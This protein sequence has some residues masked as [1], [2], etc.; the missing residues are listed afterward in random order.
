[1]NN[2]TETTTMDIETVT[3]VAPKPPKRG[4]WHPYSVTVHGRTYSGRARV[5]AYSHGGYWWVRRVLADDGIAEDVLAEW[6][7]RAFR[8]MAGGAA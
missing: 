1:M 7:G 3:M 4:V 6:N 2:E 8:P 5:L